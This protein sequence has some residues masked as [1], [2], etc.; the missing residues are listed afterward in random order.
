VAAPLIGKLV[1]FGVGLIGGSFALALKNTGAVGR[2]VG[3]GRGRANLDVARAKGI[4][5]RTHVVDGAWQEELRDAD[6]VLLAVPVGQ[7]PDLLAAIGAPSS[8]TRAVP[9]RT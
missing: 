4:A 2:V 8:P 7:M 9:S 6:L 5:D 1:V 3:I